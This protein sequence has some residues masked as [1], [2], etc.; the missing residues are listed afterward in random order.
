M[1]IDILYHNAK[2]IPSDI[3]EHVETLYNYAVS[4]QR[5]LE[6]GV[7]AGNSSWGL[8]K[9]L[10]DSKCEDKKFIQCDIEEDCPNV[11]TVS[12]IA[13]I[14]NIEHKYL[15]MNDLIIDENVDLYGLSYDITFIDTWHVYG[16]LKRELEKFSKITT[17]YIIMHDTEI[18]GVTGESIRCGWDTKTHAATLGW[19]EH[20]VAGGL[21]Q[22][23]NEFLEVSPEWKMLSQVRNNNG[24]TI[25]ERLL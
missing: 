10:C 19:T 6:L 22:A 23:I 15:V 1:D 11:T 4:S 16:Q 18:D 14:H 12:Q 20:E 2:Y 3:N 17:K 8:L 25:L 13:N 9:G 5:I 21:L 24:L 7:N